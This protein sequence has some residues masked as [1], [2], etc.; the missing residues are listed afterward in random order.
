MEKVCWASEAGCFSVIEPTDVVARPCN[1]NCCACWKDFS[2]LPH[3][4]H[5]TLRPIQATKDFGRDQ[6]L[7]LETPGL[8]VVD[9]EGNAQTPAE[10]EQQRDRI[11]RVTLVLRDRKYLFTEDVI[12]DESGAVDR[13]HAVKAKVFRLIEVL[14]PRGGYKLV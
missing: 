13:N 1:F 4:L 11:M 14:R 6:H 10:L 8:D 3:D 9:Y 5:E 12:V 2:F 7:R